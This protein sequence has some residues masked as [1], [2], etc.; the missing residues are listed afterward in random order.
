MILLESIGIA[1]SQLWAN[2]IR[3]TLTLLGMLIGVGS[4]VGIVS[5]S[6]GMRRMV[7]EEFGKLGGANF[8]YVVPREWVN[9]DGRWVR[10]AQFEPMTLEDVKHVES[11]SDRI[12]VILPMLPMSADVSVG[13]ASYQAQIEGTIPAYA[14]AYDWKLEG[15]R[16]L[17]PTDVSAN[18]RVAVVGQTIVKEV[19]GER[20]AIGREM[21]IKGQRYDVIGVMEDRKI[22]GQDWGNRVLLPVTTTQKRLMGIKRISGLFIYTKSP[23]DAPAV[24]PLVLQQLRR[25]HG[26]KAEYEF[27]SGKGIL[28]QVEQ[29]IMVM[30]MV[31]GGIAGISL[32]VGGIGIMNIMLVSVTE[33]T[34]EIGIRKALGARP[35]TLLAQFV[36]EAVVLSLFGGALGVGLGV[37]L[38]LGISAAIEHFAEFPFPSVVS[39]SSVVLALMISTVIGLFFGIFPAARAA[40]LDPVEALSFE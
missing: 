1:F 10:L 38:G 20:R 37:S 24:Q 9:R 40:R 16:F 18:R 30:K 3:S 39:S 14:K 32:L 7:Y 5:I 29:T 13:K 15:G 4:V 19:F 33:R 12:D 35:L 11:A 8:I 22:F 28:D 25:R 34:R 2:K 26:P 31:T 17:R 21:K 6:E 27:Q 23:D 36:I